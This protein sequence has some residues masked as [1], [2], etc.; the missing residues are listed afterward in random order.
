MTRVRKAMA[1]IHDLVLLLVII[2]IWH[3]SLTNGNN[4]D[5]HIPGVS[6]E[7]KVHVDAAKEHCFY[8][9]VEP[10]ANFFVACQVIR[11][12][13]GKAGFAVRHPSGHHVHPYQWQSESEYEEVSQSGGV[14]EIC[15]DNQ[16]SRFAAKLVLLYITSFQYDKW[17]NFTAELEQLDVSVTNFTSSIKVVDERIGDIQRNQQ[18]GR[19]H[20]ARDYQLLL[21]NNSYVQNWSIAQ[22]AVVFLASSLQVFFLRK[23]FDVKSVTPTSKPRA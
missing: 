1:K 5:D 6:F 16:F 11:G 10:S 23:L 19:R 22:C 17:E 2:V 9:Y 20:E 21:A 18:Y 14:Y 15:I 13:D 8:Q 7:F 4:E 3:S 12:G